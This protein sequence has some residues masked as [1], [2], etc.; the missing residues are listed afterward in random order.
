MKKIFSIL[1]GIGLVLTGG[2][3][4]TGALFWP[5]ARFY[6]RLWPLIIIAAGALLT[7]AP[8][9]ARKRSLGVMLIPGILILVNGAILLFTS[10]TGWWAAWSVLWPFEILAL[11]ASFILAA[12][13]MRSIWLTLPAVAIG[14][15]GLVLMFCA[16]SG[17][18]E[19]WTFLWTIEPLAVGVMLLIAASQTRSKGLFVSGMLFCAFA[20]ASFLGMAAI[21]WADWRMLRLSAPVLLIIAGLAVLFWGIARKQPGLPATKL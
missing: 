7:A 5:A 16:I 4:L 9:L 12:L 8:M 15:N 20:G 2:L 19:V 17:W 3:L 6:A 21:M 11:A 1:F 14:L 10:L 13:Y 18:W